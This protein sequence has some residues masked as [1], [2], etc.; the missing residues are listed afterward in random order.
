MVNPLV[1]TG[2]VLVVAGM[3]LVM[4]QPLS[5]I[6]YSPHVGDVIRYGPNDLGGDVLAKVTGV[7]T[8]DNYRYVDGSCGCWVTSSAPVSTEGYITVERLPEE[9]P[10][11][12]VPGGQVESV[13]VSWVHSVV[14]YAY[15]SAATSTTTT[16]VSGTATTTISEGT[17]VTVSSSTT[18]V[19]TTQTDTAITTITTVS[20]G[21]TVTT[22]STITLTTVGAATLT[23]VSDAARNS[24]DVSGYLG[25]GSIVVGV[26]VTLVGMKRERML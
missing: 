1:L 26:A 10:D 5:V 14:S 21:T 24:A 18:V 8:V 11:W 12:S 20:E 4:F 19:S 2:L 16:T 6:G 13:P 3:F 7:Y 9:G 25:L 15:V 17:T 23:T 22:S